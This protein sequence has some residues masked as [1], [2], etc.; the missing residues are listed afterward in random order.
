MLTAQEI[1]AIWRD[2]MRE[3]SRRGISTALTKAQV[4]S[5]LESTHNWLVANQTSFNQYLPANV[6]SDMVLATKMLMFFRIIEAI[7]KKE[8][9]EL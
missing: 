6:R 2:F 5:G 4:R 1:D 3:M 9:G 7:A 8:L